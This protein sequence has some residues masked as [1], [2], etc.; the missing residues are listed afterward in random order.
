MRSLYF[1]VLGL[2]IATLY[3]QAYWSEVDINPFPYIDPSQYFAY[4]TGGFAG[5][6]ISFLLGR[7]WAGLTKKIRKE[8]YELKFVWRKDWFIVAFLSICLVL[9]FVSLPLF[10]MGLVG[11]LGLFASYQLANSTT[12]A[13]L[14]ENIEIRRLLIFAFF[15]LP[16]FAIFAGQAEAHHRLYFDVRE[17]S[18]VASENHHE[19]LGTI[20]FGRLGDV[21]VF[22]D[23]DENRRFLVPFSS[24]E[25]FSFQ[26]VTEPGKGGRG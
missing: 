12:Y 25:G 10:L 5:I 7:A 20:Y 8:P 11:L 15:L 3:L 19:L 18:W 23:N 16:P 14:N 6:I 4:T 22:I 21:L 17:V 13:A 1:T 24:L 2:F 26:N 9:G